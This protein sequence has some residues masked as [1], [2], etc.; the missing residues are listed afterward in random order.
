MSGSAMKYQKILTQIKADW[1][2]RHSLKDVILWLFIP[3]II[4]FVVVISLISYFLAV[5]Q[6][7]NNAY[8]SISDTVSQTQKYLD[9]RLTAIFEQIVA[10][11]NDGDTLSLLKR[12]DSERHGIIKPRDYLQTDRQLERI[13]SSYY[14]MLDSILVYFNEGQLILFKKDY[15]TSRVIFEFPKW[16]SKFFGNRTEY[17]WRMLHHNETFLPLESN[18]RVASIFKLYGDQNSRA[19]GIILFNLKED[20]FRGILQD[21][22]ISENG[23]LVL[24]DSEGMMHFKD[25]PEDYEIDDVIKQMLLKRDEPSGRLMMTNSRGKKIMVIYDTV[26]VNRWKLAAVFPENDIIN[27]VAFIKNITFAVMILAIITAILLSNVLAK[28]VITPL[29]VLT[30]KV[31]QVKAGNLNVAFN[32][33]PANEIGILN[34]GIQELLARVRHLLEQVQKEQEQKRLAELETLQAQI[35][36]HFLYNTLDSIKQLCELGETKEAGAMVAALARFFRISISNGQELITMNEEFDHIRNYL[37]ILR[38]RYAD[39]FEYQIRLEPELMFCR[40]LKLTLQPLVENAVYHGIKEKRGKGLIR[41]NACLTGD[42]VFIEVY[43]NGAGMSSSQLGTLKEE[44][45][46]GC[47]DQ[48]IGLCNVH[49]RLRLHY[50]PAYGLEINSVLGEGTRVWV[51]LPAEFGGIDNG[52]GHDC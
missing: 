51:K 25:V 8:L 7:K 20:F 33:N 17:Y 28:I 46:L 32:V 47:K 34:E 36:P 14:S 41:V 35:K 9:N 18:Q 29:T 5:R 24:L 40:I 52:S 48:G 19:R 26:P 37:K 27:R 13:F 12:V 38:M 21:A 15:M 6:I 16:R 3:I 11:E 2:P 1:P 43:D 30:G 45:A 10:F 31:K 39:G 49:R 23:Y 50:G 4:F 22:Q 42:D 44:L